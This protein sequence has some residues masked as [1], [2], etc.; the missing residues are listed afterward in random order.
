MVCFTVV[1]IDF[2][3]GAPIFVVSLVAAPHKR[4]YC[5]TTSVHCMLIFKIF[6]SAH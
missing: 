5:F 2:V 4:G 1:A 3:T 6:L